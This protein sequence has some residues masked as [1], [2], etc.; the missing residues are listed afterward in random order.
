MRPKHTRK[1]KYVN[2]KEY[3][4]IS[5]PSLLCLTPVRVPQLSVSALCVLLVR[6]LASLFGRLRALVCLL[7]LR[8]GPREGKKKMV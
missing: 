7:R 8:R 2:K 1:I 3:Y 6:E 4:I 5:P